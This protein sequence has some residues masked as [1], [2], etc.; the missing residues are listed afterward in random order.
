MKVLKAEISSLVLPKLNLFFSFRF[1]HCVRN[2]CISLAFRF[3][4]IIPFPCCA[5]NFKMLTFKAIGC[6][7]ICVHM[8][9]RHELGQLEMWSLI[10]I[11]CVHSLDCK[12]QTHTSQRQKSWGR[13]EKWGSRADASNRDKQWENA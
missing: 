12:F 1:S 6:T 10:V 3:H 9:C 7:V 13:E 5:V 8:N 2:S 4:Y 11:L